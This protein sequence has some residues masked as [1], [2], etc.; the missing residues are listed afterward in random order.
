MCTGGSG[1]PGSERAGPD[2]GQRQTA[3]HDV[4]QVGCEQGLA[5]AAGVQAVV[6]DVPGLGLG[7]GRSLGP[8]AVGQCL[9]RSGGLQGRAG[10]GRRAGAG[11]RGGGVT[12]R[13][14]CSGVHRSQ[15]RDGTRCCRGSSMLPS[16][17]RRC[18]GPAPRAGQDAAPAETHL[19]QQLQQRGAGLL[20]PLLLGLAAAAGAQR[21]RG[22]HER[23]AA[24]LLR[25]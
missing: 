17:A 10:G 25:G 21:L 8:P 16:R 15:A 19:Q 12:A 2:C 13:Q 5:R 9:L 23:V 1:V 3:H 20:P 4:P 22:L 7:H 11:M 6:L 14:R 18:S 24:E